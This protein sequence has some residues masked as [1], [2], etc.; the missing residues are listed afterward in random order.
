MIDSQ[1]CGA[2]AGTFAIAE[3]IGFGAGASKETGTEIVPLAREVEGG[4]VEFFFLRLLLSAVFY[5]VAEGLIEGEG[6][7]PALIAGFE[8]L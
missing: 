6:D 4:E 2:G 5:G 8:K 3:A 1:V 7:F